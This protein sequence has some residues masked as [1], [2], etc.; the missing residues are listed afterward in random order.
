MF[1]LVATTILTLDY[2]QRGRIYMHQIQ[3]TTLSHMSV[4]MVAAQNIHLGSPEKQQPKMLRLSSTATPTQSSRRRWC[5]AGLGCL[6]A[7]RAVGRFVVSTPSWRCRVGY[8]MM[9]TLTRTRAILTLPISLFKTTL[10]PPSRGSRYPNIQRHSVPST[11][12][13]M[14]VGDIWELG[15]V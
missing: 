7:S 9:G 2:S 6:Q 3:I 15:P 12:P 14:P 8:I 4:Y 13:T 5:S 11:G 1:S 10:G